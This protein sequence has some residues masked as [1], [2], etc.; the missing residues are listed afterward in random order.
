MEKSILFP[1]LRTLQWP[2]PHRFGAVYLDDPLRFLHVNKDGRLSLFPKDQLLEKYLEVPLEQVQLV[3]DLEIYKEAINRWQDF[4]IERT[5]CGQCQA[6]RICGGFFSEIKS[7][8]GCQQVF[9]EV[10]EGAEHIQRLKSSQA[11]QIW[12][13]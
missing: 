3:Q 1:S 13:L 8:N 4:F 7:P 11:G 9:R 5:V 2:R 12:R 6:W 10:L